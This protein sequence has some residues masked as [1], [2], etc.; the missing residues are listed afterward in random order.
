MIIGGSIGILIIIWI[1][2]AEM[3]GIP[4][5]TGKVTKGTVR[6]YVEDRAV[7][8]LPV[9]YKVSMP[10]SGRIEPIKLIPGSK[11]KKGQ[12]IASLDD[13]EFNK[14]C[15]I[16]SARINAL[17][18]QI[19]INKYD[20]LEK[21]AVKESMKWIQAIDN[22]VDVSENK[23]KTSKLIYKYAEDYKT[24]LLNSGQ[25]ISRIQDS[26][27]KMEAAVKNVD[28]ETSKVMLNV[29]KV[30]DSIFKLAPVYI[31]EYLNIKR[32][33]LQVLLSS[34][35]EAEAELKLAQTRLDRCKIKSPTDGIVLKK[36]YE[37][38]HY[39][40]AGTLLLELGN[41][42][43]LQ[44]TAGIL[45]SDAINISPGNEVDI[46]APSLADIPIRGKVIRVDPKG[47]T[48]LS[49]LGVKQQ[50]VHV[51]IS[52]DKNSLKKLNHAKKTIGVDFRLQVKIYTA[53]K[54]DTLKIPRSA[55]IKNNAGAWQVYAVIDN[56]ASLKTV[57][58]GLLNDD[59]AE[60]TKGLNENDMVILA[61]GNNIQAGERITSVQ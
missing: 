8:S 54:K 4:A 49:S 20:G 51:K 50:R 27:A 30:V 23:V 18:G 56:K 48:E 57:S 34:L 46:Y 10:Q 42:N 19:K 21:T 39:L 9:L 60:I 7:T 47:Y 61:P 32:L 53:V 55:L 15:A 28:V 36:Y 6:E 24:T 3:Q 22:L 35:T 58:V 16:A 11:V 45:S 2:Y 40:P 33:K 59:E 1:I 38:F 14:E 43:E 25:A 41:L 29:F 37:N 13:T 52:F 17:Q 5:L 26:Q 12:L 31:N 44:I